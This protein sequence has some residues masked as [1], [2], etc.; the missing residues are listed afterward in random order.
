[1]KQSC[2]LHS[3]AQLGPRGEFYW[4]K[5]RR[6]LWRYEVRHGVIENLKLALLQWDHTS[7]T[8]SQT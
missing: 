5:P 3:S 2:V 8:T 7:I 1:M 6:L 4:Y